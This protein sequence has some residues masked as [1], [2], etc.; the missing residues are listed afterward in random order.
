MGPPF[1]EDATRA[2]PGDDISRVK[3]SD[4]DKDFL[5]ELEPCSI[6]Y[7]MYETGRFSIQKEA[8]GSI[9]SSEHFS[10]VV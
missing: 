5:P 1:R 3:Y 6:H 8:L 2:F 9:P 10:L 4:V 7:E